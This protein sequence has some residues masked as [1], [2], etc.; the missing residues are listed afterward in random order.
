MAKIDYQKEIGQ[1][2]GRL[3]IKS[4]VFGR[5]TKAICECDCGN[6][7]VVKLTTLKRTYGNTKSCGCL[8]LELLKN[9]QSQM[10][11]NMKE[12]VRKKRKMATDKTIGQRFGSLIIKKFVGFEKEKNMYE[13]LCD[14]GN[15]TTVSSNHLFDGSTQ[16]CGCKAYESAKK[17]FEENLS[18][19]QVEKTNVLILNDKPPVSNTSGYRNVF[20]ESSAKAWRVRIRLKGK[21]YDLG[22]FDNKEYANE[23]AQ[24]FRDENFKP[25]R[26]RYGLKNEY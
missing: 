18:P 23:V 13:C 22:Y 3:T 20:W 9:R 25:I 15:Y 7:T 17:C 21:R 11:K 26:E 6:E 24:Q 16:S 2:Y 4:L 14:C 1:K 19:Y 12:T 5:N 10:K 8:H